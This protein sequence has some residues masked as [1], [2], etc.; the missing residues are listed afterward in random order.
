M[1]KKMKFVMFDL[2]GPEGETTKIPINP[3]AT[4]T[5]LPITIQGRMSG[6]DGEPIGRPAAALVSGMK[7]LAVNCSVKEAIDRL[8]KAMSGSDEDGK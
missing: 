2:A 4:F 1:K 7:I 3:W 6:P 5:V 8:E